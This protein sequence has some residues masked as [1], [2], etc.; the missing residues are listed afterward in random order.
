MVHGLEKEE[1][2]LELARENGQL[3]KLEIKWILA[4]MLRDSWP[5]NEGGYSI[6]ISN[7]PYVRECEKDGM[8][9]NVLEHEP[10]TALFVEDGN[11]LLYYRHIAEKARKVMAPGAVLWLEINEALGAD[12]I[13][14]LETSHYREVNI[15]R[16][17]HGKERFAKALL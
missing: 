10:F 15:Y 2:A 4:D 9:A 11:A 8:E 13:K 6:V 16:D 14:L 7:P 5:K 12:M 3:N 17:I 1:A